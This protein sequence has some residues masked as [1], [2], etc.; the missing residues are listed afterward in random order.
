MIEAQRR[1]GGMKLRIAIWTAMGALVVVLWSIYISVTSPAPLGIVW[2]LAYLTC[3]ISLA[4][5]HA[6]SFYF[7]LISA[8]TYAMV[9]AVE[10]TMRRHHKL[11]GLI[12]N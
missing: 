3:P 9:G 8:A 2:N 5:H 6:L 11:T 4:R 7:V 10:E 12:S 1:R